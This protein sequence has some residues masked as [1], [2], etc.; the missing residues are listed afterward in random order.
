MV[1]FLIKKGANVNAIT[2]RGLSPLILAGSGKTGKRADM[3]SM[4]ILSNAN[5]D[6]ATKNGTT[7]LMNICRRLVFA[8]LTR[9]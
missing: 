8:K 9:Y 3:F 5:V 4:L 6:Y 1:E 7:A 2:H